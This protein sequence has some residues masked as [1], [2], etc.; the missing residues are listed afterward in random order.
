LTIARAIAQEPEIM[1]LDKPTSNLDLKH[2][3]EVLEIVKNWLKK[4]VFR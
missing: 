2:Q 4:K 1:L 3:L